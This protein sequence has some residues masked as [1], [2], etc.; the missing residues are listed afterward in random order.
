[1]L[2]VLAAGCILGG[3]AGAS[4]SF[5]VVAFRAPRSEEFQTIPLPRMG[6]GGSHQPHRKYAALCA[7]LRSDVTYDPKTGCLMVN[8]ITERD[9]TVVIRGKRYDRASVI[10]AKS[11]G[12][13]ERMRR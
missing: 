4:A 6:N 1:M 12:L 5:E 3:F 2:E 7:A 10:Q 13:P 9:E 8:G 11:S